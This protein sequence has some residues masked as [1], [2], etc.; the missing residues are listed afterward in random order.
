MLPLAI[1]VFSHSCLLLLLFK[2]LLIPKQI[3]AVYISG[4]CTGTEVD[5]IAMQMRLPQDKLI[6][7]RP[8]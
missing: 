4:Y 5:T 8:K 7:A 3:C 2:F 6:D 1:G